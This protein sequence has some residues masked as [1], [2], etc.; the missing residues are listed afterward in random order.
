M[1]SLSKNHTKKGRKI[2]KLKNKNK[3]KLTK[4]VGGVQ[5]QIH[6]FNV[7]PVS[8]GAMPFCDVGNDGVRIFYRTYGGGP[9]KV[10]LIIGL[11]LNTLITMD[12]VGLPIFRTV[13]MI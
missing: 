9:V 3:R 6:F 11:L 8:P 10:L 5:I 2:W 7:I 12:W 4:V 1:S 13:L